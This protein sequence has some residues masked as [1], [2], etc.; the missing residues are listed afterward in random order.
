MWLAAALLVLALVAPSAAIAASP[1]T[2]QYETQNHQI[3]AGGG[4][5]GP[6]APSHNTIGSLPF[7]GLDVGVLAL[8]A[9]ALLG[10]GFALRRL[11]DPTRRSSS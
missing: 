5:G 10:A 7:T 1:S 3:S 9:A 11:S 6:S 8:A 4:G 2:S